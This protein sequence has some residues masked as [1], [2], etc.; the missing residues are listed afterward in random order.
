[1][2]NYIDKH[3]SI[4]RA[5]A[6]GVCRTSPMQATRLLKRLLDSQ[7]I[8]SIGGG[9]VAITLIGKLGRNAPTR[10]PEMM[11]DVAYEPPEN[12]RFSLQRLQATEKMGFM[13]RLQR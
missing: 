13:G 4:Q 5:D 11:S 8:K 6:A 12:E 3:S 7:E 9:R 1:M 2:L 10:T